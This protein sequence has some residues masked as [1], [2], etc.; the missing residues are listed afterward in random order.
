MGGNMLGG[1]DT[2]K[3][4]A[5]KEYD[6]FQEIINICHFKKEDICNNKIEVIC[7]Y[8]YGIEYSTGVKILDVKTYKFNNQI[9]YIAY[10]PI[11][12]TLFICKD[13]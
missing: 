10:N 6:F 11:D 2:F 9:I 5:D 13:I 1:Q 7:N 3:S 12:K 4:N 8:F